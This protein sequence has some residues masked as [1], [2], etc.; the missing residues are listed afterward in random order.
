MPTWKQ[1]FFIRACFGAALQMFQCILSDCFSV[2][3]R[4]SILILDVSTLKSST[5]KADRYRRICSFDNQEST[6]TNEVSFEI[7]KSFQLI[8]EMPEGKHLEMLPESNAGFNLVNGFSQLYT[9]N[10]TSGNMMML[11]PNRLFTPRRRWNFH[12][13]ICVINPIQILDRKGY[14]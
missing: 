1:R 12:L 10:D 4:I 2:R 14:F 3:R 9:K 6:I 7:L 11:L 8:F 5:Y 13:L